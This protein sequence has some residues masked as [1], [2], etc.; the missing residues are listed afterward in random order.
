MSSDPAV[1]IDTTKL[2]IG[3]GVAILVGAVFE[4]VARIA[5]G[6]GLPGWLSTIIFFAALIG[7]YVVRG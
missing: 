7:F 5:L 2:A 1:D 3:I 4:G 6:S